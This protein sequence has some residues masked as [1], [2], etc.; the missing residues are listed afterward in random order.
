MDFKTCSTENYRLTRNSIVLSIFKK[1]IGFYF[2][3][4][5][6]VPENGSFVAIKYY[7]SLT[8]N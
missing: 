5:N 1:I 8:E 6:F 4:T 7:L 3:D 2:T